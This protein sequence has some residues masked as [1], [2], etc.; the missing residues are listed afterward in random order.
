[1]DRERELADSI[2]RNSGLQSAQNWRD[3]GSASLTQGAIPE[4]KN[5]GKHNHGY[6]NDADD[7]G[8]MLQCIRGV[9]N[10]VI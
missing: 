8:K 7:L 2:N 1:M 3:T 6:I 9:G 4:R 5:K 10:V